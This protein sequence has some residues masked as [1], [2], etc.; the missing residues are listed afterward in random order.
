MTI[1]DSN[2]PLT[3]SSPFISTS[4]RDAV[5]TSVAMEAP[6]TRDYGRTDK[7][8]EEW[9]ILIDYQLI[10][11]GRDPG[12]L[13]DEDMQPP[14]KNTIQQAIWLAGALNKAG[15][16][17]PTRIV[18]DAHGGIVFERQEG[19]LF[20]SIRLSSDGSAEYCFFK[21]SR[22]VERERLVLQTAGS[23]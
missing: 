1:G 22:L 8:S 20:E 3:K 17:P 11:W 10:E 21:N 18:P 7:A 5:S 14:S 9:Q 15:F 13:E 6:I 16:A 2:M 4:L 23:E 12:Q 19:N